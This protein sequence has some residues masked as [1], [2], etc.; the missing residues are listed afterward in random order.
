MKDPEGEILS[1]D[2]Q[3]R[4]IKLEAY[5]DLLGEF[6]KYRRVAIYRKSS[7]PKIKWISTI[8]SFYDMMFTEANEEQHKKEYGDLF[9]EIIKLDHL[10]NPTYEQLVRYTRELMKF[11]GNTG[12]TKLSKRMDQ[13][14][15]PG[16]ADYA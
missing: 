9:D 10:S 16:G 11:A 15:S 3:L 5:F 12:I 14:D 1:P 6:E 4:T 7:Y 8:I 2:K 13:K